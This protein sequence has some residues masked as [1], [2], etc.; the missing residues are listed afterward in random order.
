MPLMRGIILHFKNVS[1]RFEKCINALIV[2]GMYLL[3][4]I[5]QIQCT[6]T[7]VCH[8]VAPVQLVELSEDQAVKRGTSVTFKC[9]PNYR[10]AVV[11]WFVY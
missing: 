6:I 9:V 8:P 4:K 2:N 5:C 3:S 7:D 1:E 10:D 11:T